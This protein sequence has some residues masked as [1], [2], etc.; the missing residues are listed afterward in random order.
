MRSEDGEGTPRRA[1]QVVCS[2]DHPWLQKVE[3]NQYPNTS[4]IQIEGFN[5]LEEVE[6]Y[7]GKNMAYI[8]KAKTK[9]KGSN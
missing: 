4:L 8:Y 3:S 1:Y 2:R 7:L 5:T 9:Q 6:W